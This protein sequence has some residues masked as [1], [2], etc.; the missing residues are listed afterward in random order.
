MRKKI[1]TGIVIGVVLF[2]LAVAIAL[3]G[4]GGKTAENTGVGEQIAVVH[5]EG[6]IMTSAP[7]G[8]GTAG[9][10]AADRIV[11]ELKQAR[12]IR[13]IKAVIL[14]PSTRGDNCG[15]F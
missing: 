7:G 3:K 4:N 14:N 2:S 8:F 10:A 1:I 5:I 6:T 15:G 13:E 11:S 12:E 9:V